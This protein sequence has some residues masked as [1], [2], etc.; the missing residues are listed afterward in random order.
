VSALLDGVST[1]IINRYVAVVTAEQLREGERQK[2][3]LK[4]AQEAVRS[5]KTIPSRFQLHQQL[6]LIRIWLCILWAKE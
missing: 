6:K 3:A 1:V 4:K 2:F 5:L